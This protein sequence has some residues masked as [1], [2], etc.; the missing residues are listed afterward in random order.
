MKIGIIGIGKMGS[1]ILQGL[2]NTNNASDLFIADSNQEN[3]DKIKQEV[4]KTTAQVIAKECDMI[5][6]AVKPQDFGSLNIKGDNVFISIMAGVKIDKIKN[7]VGSSKIIRVMPNLA[8]LVQEAS[9]AYCCSKSVT[10]E[11]KKAAESLLKTF[12]TA[13]EVKEEE[14]DAVTGLSGSGPAYVA[15]FIQKLAEAGEKEGLEESYKQALQTVFGTAKLLKEKD[16]KPEELIAMVS[17]K[18]GTTEKGMEVLEGSDLKEI[19][20]KT[21]AKAAERSRE[22]GK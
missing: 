15:Y 22:L 19:L 6:I 12:G 17:S 7:V 16:I 5:I 9:S 10:D 4:N 11:E 20:S 21:V 18:K 3:L 2:L 8:A 1:A 14:M 13:F